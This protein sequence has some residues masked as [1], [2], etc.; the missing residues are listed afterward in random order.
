MEA[1]RQE[2]ENRLLKLS[3]EVSQ[4]TGKYRPSAAASGAG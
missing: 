3:A 2:L 1:K 4:A